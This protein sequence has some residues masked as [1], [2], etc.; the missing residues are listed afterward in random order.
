MIHL[1]DHTGKDEVRRPTGE[2][3]VL[4]GYEYAG[5]VKEQA[6][7]HLLLLG[8]R[9]GKCLGGSH[10]IHET[11]QKMVK[12][13]VLAHH[14]AGV[15]VEDFYKIEA[16]GVECT[17]KCGGCRCSRCSAGSKDYTLREE[18]ELKLI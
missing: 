11:T 9:F 5:P 16:M 3:E 8:N 17:P 1:I 6:V 10:P 4:I 2:V 14:V 7:G 12:N 15:K 13:A 18:Q